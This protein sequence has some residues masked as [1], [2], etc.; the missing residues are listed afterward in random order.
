MELTQTVSMVEMLAILWKKPKY[1]DE[2]R[3]FQT[4]TGKRTRALAVTIDLLQTQVLVLQLNFL[5][6]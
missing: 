6:Y 3:R 5:N 4:D 2:N 1:P